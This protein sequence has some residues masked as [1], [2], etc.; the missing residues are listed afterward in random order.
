MV[1]LVILIKNGGHGSSFAD[2]DNL[3]NLLNSKVFFVYLLVCSS[4]FCAFLV[5]PPF[6]FTSLVRDT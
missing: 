3:L 4:F 2:S 6:G 5:F 1:G